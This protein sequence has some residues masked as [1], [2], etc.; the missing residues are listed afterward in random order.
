MLILMQR[1]THRTRANCAFRPS[2][3]EHL[4]ARRGGH[5]RSHAKERQRLLNGLHHTPSKWDRDKEPSED[6]FHGFE[7]A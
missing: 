6:K 4:L 7:S 2:R 5:G 1:P 3:F